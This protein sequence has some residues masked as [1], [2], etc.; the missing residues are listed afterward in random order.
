MYCISLRE[1][2]LVTVQGRKEGRKEGWRIERVSLPKCI[3][4]Q[5][6]QFTLRLYL[7]HNCDSHLGPSETACSA[8]SS[9]AARRGEEAAGGRAGGG[10]GNLTC[11]STSISL[12]NVY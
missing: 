5:E 3:C 12:V 1:F 11:A 8:D 4:G 9:W 6:V 7:N 2:L 10:G